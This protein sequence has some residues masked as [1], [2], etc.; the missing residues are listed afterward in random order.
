[1][2]TGL[3]P[4]PGAAG[5]SEYF[6]AKLFLNETNPINGFFYS[7]ATSEI[8]AQVASSSMCMAALLLWR[9]ITFTF[10][11]IVGGIVTA[12]Y[13]TSNKGA[14]QTDIHFPERQTMVELQRETYLD[15]KIS[16]DSLVETSRLTRDA[17]LNKIKK[18]TQKPKTKT[19]KRDD[20]IHQI[21]VYD[22]GDD[23]I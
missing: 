11:L 10:P 7:P 6:F 13:K 14:K 18:K 3:I 1:M 5:V 12:F 20:S 8:S 19:T 15:R 2:V 21:D 17:I 4:I 9:T 23:T 16:S 22:D